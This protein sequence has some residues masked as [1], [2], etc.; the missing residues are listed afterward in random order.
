MEE[1]QFSRRLKNEADQLLARKKY[2]AAEKLYK[3]A[4]NLGSKEALFV[5]AKRYLEGTFGSG[6]PSRSSQVRMEEVGEGFKYLKRA[7]DCGCEEAVAYA[8]E[9]KIDF[10]QSKEQSVP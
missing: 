7:I 10:S 2:N 3:Q 6:K 1:I 8:Q 9:K 5:L 4:A